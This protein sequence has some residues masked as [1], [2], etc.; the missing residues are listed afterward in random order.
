MATQ[1]GAVRSSPH[2]AGWDPGVLGGGCPAGPGSH[3]ALSWGHSLRPWGDAEDVVTGPQTPQRS[4]SRRSGR[5]WGW[6]RFFLNF[7]KNFGQN[8]S[9]SLQKP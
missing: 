6:E 7:K 3:L 4:S 5:V 8:Y 2:S 9:F 1:G